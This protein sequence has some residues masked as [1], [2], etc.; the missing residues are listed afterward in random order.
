M[1]TALLF[2]PLAFVVGCSQGN[3]YAVKG[4]APAEGADAT[5]RVKQTDTGNQQL[6][7]KLEHLPPP[8]RLRG[9]LSEYVVWVIPPDGEPI[10]AGI[11]TYDEKDREGKLS[12]ITPYRQFDVKVT[13]EAQ[14]RPDKPGDVVIVERG[15]N[16]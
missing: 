11:L 1:I 14:P 13:A 5:I 10:H 9:D 6:Q 3:K 15:I 12:T 2:A 7:V 8:Q 16:K 4:N